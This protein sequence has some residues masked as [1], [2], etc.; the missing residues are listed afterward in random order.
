M[1]YMYASVS[2][3]IVLYY[4]LLLLFALFYMCYYFCV[5]CPIYMCCCVCCSGANLL[6]LNIDG[7]MPYDI[8][9]D[10]ETLDIIELEMSKR[11]TRTITISQALGHR[12]CSYQCPLTIITQL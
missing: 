11:G 9:E 4:V 1:M 5:Y 8:C 6:A 10:E 2:A 12:Y 7:N 3:G